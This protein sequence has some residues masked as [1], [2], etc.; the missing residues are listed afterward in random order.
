MKITQDLH[1]HTY[2]SL[3]AEK[4]ATL[5]A[6]ISQASSLGLTTLGIADHLWDD[7]VGLHD[8]NGKWYN[9]Y[10][11]QNMEHVLKAREDSK[12]LDTKGLRVL[13]G[14]EVEYDCVRGDLALSEEAAEILD[15]MI[16]PNSHTHL[17]M[18]REYYEPYET[19]ARFML[20]AARNILRSPLVKYVSA[21]AHPFD[22]VCCPYDRNV[23]YS[24]ISKSEY[25]DLFCEASEKNVAM[26]INT[27]TFLNKTDEEI[28][29]KPIWEIMRLAKECGCK[30]TFGSDCHHPKEQKSILTAKLICDHINLTED[31]I[32][33]L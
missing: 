27:S 15:F 4:E 19:H 14:A 3:C 8:E 30:F 24:L 10:K 9:F 33:I 1:M 13:F 31:D 22:A 11:P 23:L 6:Y 28:K 26:E 16:V 5:E 7:K 21:I 25:K 29:A 2:L 20:N 32:L 18:P 17:V 12:S